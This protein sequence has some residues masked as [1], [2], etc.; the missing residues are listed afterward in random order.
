[1]QECDEMGMQDFL[2]EGS[3]RIAL[4]KYSIGS[5]NESNEGKSAEFK[6]ENSSSTIFI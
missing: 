2:S 4:R 6:R 5:D 1:M 3:A